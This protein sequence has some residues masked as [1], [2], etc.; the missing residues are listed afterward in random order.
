M[1]FGEKPLIRLDVEE[2]NKIIHIRRPFRSVGVGIGRKDGC[3]RVEDED[4]MVDRYVQNL[5]NTSGVN[6][7]LLARHC[8][9]KKF[10]LEGFQR[11]GAVGEDELGKGKQ[12]VLEH[13]PAGPEE[14]RRSGAPGGPPRDIQRLLVHLLFPSSLSLVLRFDPNRETTF[15][16]NTHRKRR[17]NLRTTQLSPTAASFAGERWRVLAP[18]TGGA[19]EG[20]TIGRDDHRPSCRSERLFAGPTFDVDKSIIYIYM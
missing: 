20:V 1:T 12:P 10:P 5:R 18:A 15:D 13:F 17:S 2:Y 11:G 8:P 19:A 3:E 16:R 6:S 4:G 7:Y 9:L 14:D